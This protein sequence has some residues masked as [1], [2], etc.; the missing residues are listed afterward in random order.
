MSAD[1][2]G[3]SAS[4]SLVATSMRNMEGMI[5]GKEVPVNCALFKA[6]DSRPTLK[7]I[8]TA[9]VTLATFIVICFAAV[10][11]AAAQG[12]TITD[13]GTLG[14]DFSAAHGINN[15]GQVVGG[16][17]VPDGRERAFIWQEGVMQEVFFNFAPFTIATGINGL[18]QV[19]GYGFTVDREHDL[20]FLWLNGVAQSLGTLPNSAYSNANAIN[21]LGQVVGSSGERRPCR[22]RPPPHAFLWQNGLMQDLGTLPG[23]VGNCFSLTPSSSANGINNSGQVVGSSRSDN[24]GEHA[25]LWQNGLMQD[26]GPGTATAINN[27][28][29]VVGSSG[30]HAFLWQGGMMEDLGALSGDGWSSAL[31]IN[32]PGQ[33]VGWSGNSGFPQRAFLWQSGVMQDLNNLI[34]PG[35]GW[36]LTQAR[37]INDAGQIVGSGTLNGQTRAFLLTPEASSTEP[38]I[39]QDDP[40]V[41]YAGTWYSNAHSLHS[42][43]SA[44]LSMEAGARATVSFIGTGISWIGYRDEWSGIARVYIDGVFVSEVDTY[45][46]AGGPQAVLYSTSGLSNAAHTLERVMDLGGRLRHCHGLLAATAPGSQ[47]GARGGE[48]SGGGLYRRL[49]FECPLCAQRR[50]RRALHGGRGPGDREFHRERRQLDRLSRPVEWHSACIYRWGLGG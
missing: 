2:G 1:G 33:V 29:Q 4:G 9:A 28:G 34:P 12:Y 47:R 39:E 25:F 27:S 7:T 14:G 6:A 23:S 40:S 20:A 43:G 49:V 30:G 15:A 32:G 17:A 18:G 19:V 24:F 26:L 21:D 16:A 13:L 5:S 48:R 42:G 41:S 35:S 45:L 22:N 31:G 11:I 37:S 10:G 44:V 50:Q 38:R 8:G 3:K 46:G 36:T